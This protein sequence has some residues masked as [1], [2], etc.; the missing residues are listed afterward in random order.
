MSRAAYKSIVLLTIISLLIFNPLALAKDRTG[1]K[2][3]SSR[4]GGHYSGAHSL[5]GSTS[6][7][8]GSKINVGS[9]KKLSKTERSRSAKEGFLKQHGL[10]KVPDGCQVDHKIPL[11]AGGRDDPSNMQILTEGE[12]K[13]KTMEDLR[14]YSK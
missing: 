6:L 10:T 2:Q 5:K 4:S 3:S 11:W 12:H 14:K 1:S 7:H 8:S 9:I 13:R